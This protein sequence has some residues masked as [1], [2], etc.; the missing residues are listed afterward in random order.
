M[1]RVRGCAGDDG[2]ASRDDFD[3]GVDNV[4]PFIMGQSRSLAR[5]AARY[6]EVDARFYLPR[7]QIAQ[8]GVVDGAVLMERSN[9]SGAASTELHRDKIARMSGEGK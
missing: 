1:R 5:G 9:Q 2:D 7:D 6:K 4:Q 3:G 8:G